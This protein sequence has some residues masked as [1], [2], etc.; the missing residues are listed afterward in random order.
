MRILRERGVKEP[1]RIVD[2]IRRATSLDE[3]GKIMRDENTGSNAAQFVHLRLTVLF[4]GDEDFAR[5]VLEC[6]QEKYR[7]LGLPEEIVNF[8]ISDGGGCDTAITIGLKM[9]LGDMPKVDDINKLEQFSGSA[10]R[11]LFEALREYVVD[12]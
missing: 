11:Y 8:Y 3:L 6:A 2:T 1:E 4:K 5:R 12:S 7:E 9:E 10:D